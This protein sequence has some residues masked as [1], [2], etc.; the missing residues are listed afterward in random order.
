MQ[1]AGLATKAINQYVKGKRSYTKKSPYWYNKPTQVNMPAIALAAKKAAQTVLSKRRKKVKMEYVAKGEGIETR[2]DL[3][4]P[5]SSAVK[6]MKKLNPPN[7]VIFNYGKQLTWSVG[8]QGVSSWSYF[9]NYQ[10]GQLIN[11]LPP[12]DI[13]G[14]NNRRFLIDK[15]QSEITLANATN[16][17]CYVH[18][19][20]IMCKVDQDQSETTIYTP[21]AAWGNGEV[22]QGNSSGYTQIGTDPKKI[23]LFKQN[24]RI[25]KHQKHFLGP[26]DVQKHHININYNKIF[27]EARRDTSTSNNWGNFTLFTMMVGYGTPAA[28]D[29]SNT[30]VSTTA[31]V[32]NTTYTCKYT[33]RY[34]VDNQ[35]SSK[36][37]N[38]LSQPTDLE[39]V[40]DDGDIDLVTSA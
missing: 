13:A 29:A 17:C 5:P 30:T 15:F 31:G 35:Q 4:Y 38:I 2:F 7:N 19:Y 9:D 37:I 14:N 33:F 20:D 39:V 26:G 11:Q 6:V 1:L 34:S 27:N 16:A 12:V 25:L 32:V 21:D 10:M 8:R 18:V 22:A 3:S 36:S 23:D 40:Q 24:Y 28:G